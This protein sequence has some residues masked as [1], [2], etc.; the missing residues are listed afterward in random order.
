M[1]DVST[2]AALHSRHQALAMQLADCWLCALAV[3]ALLCAGRRRMQHSRSSPLPRQR[4]LQLQQQQQ[5]SWRQA[6]P[7]S[8][9]SSKPLA[10]AVAM[11]QQ[12]H[13]TQ[14]SLG[15][16]ET[17]MLLA[18]A[19]LLLLLLLSVAQDSQHTERSYPQA[20]P[21]LVLQYQQQLLLLH[22]QAHPAGRCL[23][24]VRLAAAGRAALGSS[25][26][27]ARL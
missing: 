12:T 11:Q 23:C 14:R 9:S 15:K 27:G 5:P 3:H 24:A 17:R 1:L 4:P 19:L 8:S 6:A 26:Q 10:A 7:H 21:S 20:Q 2:G 13:C 16:T 18:V 22:I 25:R